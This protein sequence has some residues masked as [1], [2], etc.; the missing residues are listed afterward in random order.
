MGPP[1]VADYCL[2]LWLCLRQRQRSF[3][4]APRISGSGAIDGGR[5]RLD[6]A[7]E[8]GLTPLI[9]RERE[10]SLL[11]ELFQLHRMMSADERGDA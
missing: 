5:A 11:L 1:T 9:G 10:L 8:R 6:V 4:L 2:W 7:V 3:Q